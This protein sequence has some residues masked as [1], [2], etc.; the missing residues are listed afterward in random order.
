M[1]GRVLS[2]I[3]AEKPTRREAKRGAGL[4]VIT[5]RRGP[6]RSHPALAHGGARSESVRLGR[7]PIS[8]VRFVGSA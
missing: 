6:T 1:D 4:L 8:V 3:G 7:R 5:L 2:G